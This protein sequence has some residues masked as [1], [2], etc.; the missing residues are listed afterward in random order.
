MW[1]RE[2]RWNW[3]RSAPAPGRAASL[4]ASRPAAFEPLYSEPSVGRR[5]D[6]VQDKFAAIE[7]PSITAPK[8]T[9]TERIAVAMYNALTYNLY[10]GGQGRLR[11]FIGSRSTSPV[12]NLP[13]SSIPPAAGRMRQSRWST[14]ASY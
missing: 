4:P 6:G 13:L 14:R 2:L 9:P 5:R 8:G 1:W 7:I 3:R 11:R 12:R 10:S